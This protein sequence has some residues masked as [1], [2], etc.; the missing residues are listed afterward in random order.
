MVRVGRKESGFLAGKRK[1]T[2]IGITSCL[3]GGLTRRFWGATGDNR[4]GIG[5][6]CC[7]RPFF[8]RDRCRF[9]SIRQLVMQRCR[10]ASCL[11]C[12]FQGLPRD[13]RIPNLEQTLNDEALDCTAGEMQLLCK[14]P[15]SI[16]F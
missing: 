2:M 4:N 10:K 6:R 16:S 7:S 1:L 12:V 15:S 8:A 13:A 14:S 3:L 5:R 9:F 11:A